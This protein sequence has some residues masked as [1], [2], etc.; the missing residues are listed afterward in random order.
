MV[1]IS[2]ACSLLNNDCVS[3]FLNRNVAHFSNV[4]YYDLS[5]HIQLVIKR[6]VHFK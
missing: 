6:I 1:D 5:I 3:N 4:S 2:Q